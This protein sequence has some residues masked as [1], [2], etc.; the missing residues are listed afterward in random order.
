MCL[1]AV[2]RSNKLIILVTIDQLVGVQRPAIVRCADFSF[3]S[4][5]RFCKS[6]TSV[7]PKKIVHAVRMPITT[8]HE[9]VTTTFETEQ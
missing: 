7:F 9:S 8:H 5:D 4:V 1:S 6:F 2:A 3:D